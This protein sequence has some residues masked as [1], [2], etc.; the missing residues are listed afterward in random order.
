MCT[1]YMPSIYGG[2]KKRCPIPGTGALNGGEVPHGS[3]DPLEGQPVP[4]TSG[5]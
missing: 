5:P 1:M 2:Q 4:L 3:P